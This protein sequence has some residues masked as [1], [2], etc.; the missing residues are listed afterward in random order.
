MKTRLWSRPFGSQPSVQAREPRWP[1]GRSGSSGTGV[2]STRTS[3]KRLGR[4]EGFGF[5]GPDGE[6][7]LSAK[8]RSGIVR[9]SGEIEIFGLGRREAVVAA[10]L[11]SYLLIRR[12]E[13]AASAATAG[14]VV[15]SS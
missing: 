13:Q 2:C 7:V 9:S 1:A 15:A 5:V 12:N 4:K 11:A 6:P 3:W 10:L 8:V 14:V